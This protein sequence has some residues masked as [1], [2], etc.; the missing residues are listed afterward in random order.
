M[1]NLDPKSI[2]GVESEGMVLAAE[3]GDGVSLLVPDR[4]LEEGSRVR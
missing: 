2:A 3:G 4:D 1:V